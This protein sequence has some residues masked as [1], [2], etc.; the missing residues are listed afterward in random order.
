MVFNSF[1]TE[2]P[3]ASGLETREEELSDASMIYLV[4]TS[5][6]YLFS[7][8]GRS[9]ILD[10]ITASDISIR[11]GQ[12]INTYLMISQATDSISRGSLRADPMGDVDNTVKN[13][14]TTM[15]I[16]DTEEIYTINTAWLAAFFVTAIAML[17][18]SVVGAVFCHSSVTPEILGFASA[19]IR[20]SR[21]VNLAPGFGGLG[22]LE[23]T[24]AFEKIEFR[25][26][27]VERSESGQDV[28]GVSWKVNAGRVKKG[29]PY[30]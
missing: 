4:N 20:D 22:G 24:K 6:S 7:Q 29:V 1:S 13:V 16:V 26:G 28:L 8:E 3:M 21:Y 10:N 11:L 27:V 14:T 18:G 19:A 5:T 12:I 2:L 23:M 9:A 15:W 17:V 25:Y 30:V